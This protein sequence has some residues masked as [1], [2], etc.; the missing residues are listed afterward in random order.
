MSEF[1]EKAVLPDS[2]TGKQARR[3]PVLFNVFNI[4]VV[5]VPLPLM[6]FWLGASM[7]LYAMNR[8]HP[9]PK[10]AEYIQAAAIRLYGIAGAAV[11]VGTFFSLDPQPWLVYWALAALFMIPFSIRD[12][13]RIRS[14]NWEDTD[15]T[16]V[17]YG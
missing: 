11:P 17:N 14:D 16:G 2:I 4:I 15:L 12:L 9:N 13:A 8:H 7:V 1:H 6:V 3:A 10:V 5:L